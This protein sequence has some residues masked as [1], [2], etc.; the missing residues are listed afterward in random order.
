MRC[1][2]NNRGTP[3]RFDLLDAHLLYKGSITP[4]GLDP[5]FTTQ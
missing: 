4:L 3:S 1:H 5:G 2:S